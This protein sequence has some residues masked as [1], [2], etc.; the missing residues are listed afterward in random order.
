MNETSFLPADRVEGL[1]H[2]LCEELWERDDQVR[3]LACQSVESEP[4]VA[5]PLQYLLCTLDLPGGRAAL[6]QA[7]PAWR[8]ALD[9]LGALLD[10]A[11]DVW[12]EDRRGWAPFV[13]LHKAPFPI[14]R[15]SGPDLRDWDVL[16]VMERDACF[17][18]SWQGLLERLHQQ[19]SRENQRDIQ[20]VL[21]LDAFE[22][23]FGVNLR[24]VLSGEPEI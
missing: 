20:R 19:G 16:L 12:A 10:H 17:G 7:L 18:G 2:M 11:D 3:L 9:D 24:R 1:L 6:R 22:R 21:Q 5:V 15:P 14:R 4:G 8:S 23:A 13:T